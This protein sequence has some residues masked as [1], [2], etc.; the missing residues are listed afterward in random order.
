MKI[1]PAILRESLAGVRQDLAALGGAS[2]LVSID[3]C[4]GK[5]VPSQTWL[6]NQETPANIFQEFNF[7]LEFDL[8]V[9]E[10]LIYLDFL[11]KIGAKKVVIHTDDS[12]VI[13]QSLDFCQKHALELGLVSQDFKVLKKFAGQINYIQLMGIE[14]L[15]YQKQPFLEESLEKIKTIRNFYG[16]IIQIDGG[17]NLLNIKKCLQA[18]AN[19]FVLGSEIFSSGNP[20]ENYQRIILALNE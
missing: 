20:K 15:G 10:P 4:D 3:L 13:R 19:N 1:I 11:K 9:S 2:D 17:L 18:G 14:K 5:F 6:P 12:E 16:G 8:L 7:S